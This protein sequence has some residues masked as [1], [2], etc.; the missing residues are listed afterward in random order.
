MSEVVAIRG[1][2]ATV[3]PVEDMTD[4]ELLVESVERMRKVED[5]VTGFIRDLSS[6]PMFAMLGGGGLPKFGK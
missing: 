4:R 3:K 1:S 5:L 2:N 6:N